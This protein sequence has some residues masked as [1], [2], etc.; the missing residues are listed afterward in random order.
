MQSEAVHAL[1]MHLHARRM[2]GRGPV[3]L[4]IR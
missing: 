1:S 2:G 3:I 4:H